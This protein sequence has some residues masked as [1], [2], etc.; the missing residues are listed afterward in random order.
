M[1]VRLLPAFCLLVLPALAAGGAAARELGQDELR[2]LS[3]SGASADM[4]AVLDMVRR[5][6]R[7]EPMDVRAFDIGGV[8]YQVIVMRPDGRMVS[9]VVD[10]R[11]G[12][13]VPS[14]AR[15]AR[16]VRAE[17]AASAG[18]NGK[19]RGRGNAGGNQ[20]N[21]GN[22]GGNNGNGNSGGNGNGGGNGNS[23]NNGN[24]NG[25]GKK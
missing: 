2:R 1:M 15:A 17:A 19:G 23:G 8:Y 3:A 22:P 12:R 14:N 7:G 18:N 11:T 24:G 10:A 13:F 6:V 16:E 4:A 9:V 5:E 21:N 25:G 20:G